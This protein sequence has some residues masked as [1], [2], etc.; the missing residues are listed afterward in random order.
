L[1]ILLLQL[2]QQVLLGLHGLLG[3]RPELIMLLLQL[4]QLLLQRF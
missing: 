4:L 2:L 3:F 1:H